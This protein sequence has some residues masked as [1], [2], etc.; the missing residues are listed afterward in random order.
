MKV[1]SQLW[2]PAGRHSSL[3]EK[4]GSKAGS[5]QV[6][7]ELGLPHPCTTQLC[8]SVGQLADACEALLL[9]LSDIQLLVV[10]LNHTAGGRGNAPLPL[11]LV[12]WR[13]QPALFQ[14]QMLD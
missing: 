14:R 9:S 1:V 10:K 8:R 7:A 4:L 13:R 5:A 11:E 2:A 12:T 3:P 6:F